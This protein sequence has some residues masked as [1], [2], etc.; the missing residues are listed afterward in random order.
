MNRN[1]IFLLAALV[2]SPWTTQ[3]QT[4]PCECIDGSGDGFDETIAFDVDKL[5]NNVHM[6]ALV[7]NAHDEG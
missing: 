3:A 7:V 2:C 5:P 1:V 4:V 6:V